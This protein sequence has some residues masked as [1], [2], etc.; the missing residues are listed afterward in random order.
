MYAAEMSIY[1]PEMLIFLDETGF[2]KRNILRRYA[3][4]F[5]GKPPRSHKLLV[6]GKHLNAIAFTSVFGIIA[7]L[8]VD[9]WMVTSFM[10]VQKYLLPHLMPFNWANPHSV[11][12]MDNAST[13]HVN[14]VVEMIQGVGAMVIFLPSYRITTR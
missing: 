10:C 8:S 12:M 1:S 9:L 13:H 14:E 11:V 2:D 4:S 5:R 7:I 6:R 3:Y